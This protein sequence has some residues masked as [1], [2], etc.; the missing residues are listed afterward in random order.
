MEDGGATTV[1][2]LVFPEGGPLL[3]PL[4]QDLLLAV[5]LYCG[6]L[7]LHPVAVLLGGEPGLV[8]GG[9][10]PTDCPEPWDPDFI[11]CYGW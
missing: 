7:L 1:K 5:F 4:Y 10:L 9:Q 3:Q 2:A 11:R 6:S 8:I